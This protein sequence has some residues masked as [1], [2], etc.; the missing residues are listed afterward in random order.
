MKINRELIKEKINI[1]DYISR[2]VSLTKRGKNY[3]GLCPF[4]SEKTPSF[5]VSESKQ[6]FYCFGCHTGG[7]LLEFLK[8]YLKLDYIQILE[9]LEKETGLRLFERD[10]D[11]EKKQKEIKKIIEINKKALVFFIN[12]LYKTTDGVKSFNLFKKQKIIFGYN[13]KVLFRLWWSRLG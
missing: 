4:H 10:K 7:D 1:V 11:Y 8:K 5:T 2:Y 3:V 6:I 13:Q 9:N 12:N